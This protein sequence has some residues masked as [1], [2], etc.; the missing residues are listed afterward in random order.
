MYRLE[1]VYFIK[2]LFDVPSLAEAKCDNR[3]LEMFFNN[4]VANNFVF[5]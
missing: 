3:M 4:F 2:E 1:L 5:N